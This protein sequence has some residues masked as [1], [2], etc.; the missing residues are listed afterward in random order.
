MLWLDGVCVV[1]CN[2]VG[3]LLTVLLVEK[4]NEGLFVTVVSAVPSAF[5]L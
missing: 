3:L 5:G 2:Y 4:E 1:A